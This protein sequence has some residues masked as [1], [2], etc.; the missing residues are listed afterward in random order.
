MADAADKARIL[1]ADDDPVFRE[2]AASCLTKAGYEVGLASE[3]AEAMSMLLGGR[4]DLAM[5]DLIMPRIDGLRL[6]GLIR[7][8]PKLRVLPIL[9]VT[10][11]EDPLVHKEGLQVGANDYLIKPIEWASL[12]ER[13]ETLLNT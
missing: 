9:V 1:V 2:L 10:S 3:G 4:F 7:A 12:P 13:I 6:L 5:V 8:T 11:E